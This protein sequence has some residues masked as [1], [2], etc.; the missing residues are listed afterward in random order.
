MLSL[1]VVPLMTGI[2]GVDRHSLKIR[3][4][5]FTLF[6]YLILAFNLKIISIFSM[7]CVFFK[8]AGY[9]KLKRHNAIV[10][11]LCARLFK[12]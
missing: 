9:L 6:R 3:K 10:M 8:Y 5:P 7:C 12:N 4:H 2:V 11:L 1:K